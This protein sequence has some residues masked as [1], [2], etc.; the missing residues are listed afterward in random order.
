MPQLDLN[1]GFLNIENKLKATKAFS[2]LNTQYKNAKKQSGKTFEQKKSDI[3]QSLSG[4]S[5][6]IDNISQTAKT[7]QKKVKTQFEELLN[8]SKL[9][10]NSNSNR[11]IKRKL[12]ET[13]RIIEPQ[14]S[15]ILLEDTLKA[16]GCDQTQTYVGG[17]KIYLKLSSIDYLGI[18][19]Q[20]PSSDQAKPLYEKNDTINPQGIP[21]SMNRQLYKRIQSTNDYK[22]DYNEEYKGSSGQGLFNIKFLDNHPI[23]NESG[24]WY[25]I[26]L[27]NRAGNVNSVKEFIVDYYTSI[28]IFEKQNVMAGIIEAL[29]GAISINIGNGDYTID[30]TSKL[31]IYIQR[32]LGL[33][34]DNRSEIDVAGTS[35]ISEFDGDDQ[36]FYELNEIDLRN[37]NSRRNNIKRGVVQFESCDNVDLPVNYLGLLNDLNTITFVKDEDFVDKADKLTNNIVDD[38]N[39]KGLGFDLNVD[40]DIIKTM[41]K[42]LVL[43]LF[44]PKVLLPIFSMVESLTQNAT[45]VIDSFVKFMKKFSS[46]V[47]SVISKIGGLFVKTLFTIIKSDIVRLI[48]SVLRDLVKERIRLKYRRII[49]LIELLLI[50]ARFVN[51]WRQC[52][53]VIDELFMLLNLARGKSF[54]SGIPLPLLFGSQLLE[55]TSPTRAYINTIEDLQ[56]LGIPTGPMPDGSPNLTMLSMFSSIKGQADEL[57]ENGKVEIAIPPLTI[58]PAGITIPLKASGK[59]I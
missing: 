38:E 16:I 42:G 19:K 57:A 50:V 31:F 48:Q 29:T 23:T 44:S 32:I 7:Y 36:S 28:K 27:S 33:C 3:V 5:K 52:K 17:Q 2:D 45:Q 54:G 58:T 40:D 8:L 11:Y 53:S 37:I 10:S 35:K 59:S 22:T 18:L 34:F 30:D 43:S 25:E 20:D 21:Y 6:K 41:V 49:K 12:L 47:K 24:G 9:T 1:N 56:S 15:T 14:I 4:A 51:D 39:K 46:Y 55:G 26:T 13:I